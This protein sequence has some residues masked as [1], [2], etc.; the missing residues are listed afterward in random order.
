MSQ[1]LSLE[2][3]K[4]ILLYIWDIYIFIIATEEYEEP[5][6]IPEREKD[7]AI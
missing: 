1:R 4:K 7:T 6:Y 2:L 5:V 3:K